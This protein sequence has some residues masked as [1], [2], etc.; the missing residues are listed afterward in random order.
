MR[1]KTCN[2]SLRL[3]FFF[4]PLREQPFSQRRE[5]ELKAQSVVSFSLLSFEAIFQTL[6]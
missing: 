4:A 6:K 5:E 2:S 3:M 1:F